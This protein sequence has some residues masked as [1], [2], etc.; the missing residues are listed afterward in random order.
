MERRQNTYG[1]KLVCYYNLEIFDLHLR[2]VLGTFALKTRWMRPENRHDALVMKYHDIACQ[3]SARIDLVLERMFRKALSLLDV[4]K[5][6]MKEES[7]TIKT[8]QEIVEYVERANAERLKLIGSN[9]VL[10]SKEII[11]R[12]LWYLRDVELINRALK[13]RKSKKI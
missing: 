6:E 11:D 2:H 3:I 4:I 8:Y 5:E 12:L 10:P 9:S 7:I 13:T 1:R